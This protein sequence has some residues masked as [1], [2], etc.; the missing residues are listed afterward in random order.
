MSQLSFASLTPK[1]KKIRAEKFLEEMD[2][3]IPWRKLETIIEP[4]YT[5]AGNGRRPLNLLLMIKIY[6]LQQWYNLSDPGMEEAIYDRLSF[7]RFLEI[8]LMLDRIPD[9]TTILQ[10]RHL[11]EQHDLTHHIFLLITGYLQDKGLLL[12]KGTIVDATIVISPSSTKN[13]EKKRDPEMSSTKK[14]GN[15]HFGMKAHIGADVKSGLVHSLEVT[16]A[17]RSDYAEMVNLLHGEEEAVFG[18]KGY[19]CE[20]DKHYA[21]DVELPL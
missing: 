9:E 18:D 1:D 16:T 8:D 20:K 19:S 4:H 11:L 10:F 14:N 17:K 3:V 21:R 15:H 13:K 7:Q 6:C 2:K 5:K 12:K